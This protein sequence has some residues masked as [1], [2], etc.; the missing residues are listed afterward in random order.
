[1]ERRTNERRA[2]WLFDIDGTLVDSFD[3][4]HLRPL[5]L[6][7]FATIQSSGAAIGVWSAGGIAHAEHVAQ[8]HG[9]TP[10]ITHFFEK[11]IHADGYWAVHPD[12]LRDYSPIVCVDDQPSRLPS[13]VE[14]IRVFPYLRP[15]PHDRALAPALARAATPSTS[16]LR[17]ARGGQ[18]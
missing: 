12:A 13:T 4:Q 10:A 7:L 8:R 18:G 6:E 1:M 9:L 16:A 2:L 15:N 5:V 11:S 14:A 3:A 17:Q